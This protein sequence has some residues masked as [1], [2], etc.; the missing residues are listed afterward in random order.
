MRHA[1]RIGAAVVAPLVFGFPGA[2][3]RAAAE[4]SPLTEVIVTAQ[5]QEQKL[6]E[7]P[8]A[9]TAIS[10]ELLDARGQTRIADVTAQAPNVL[11]QINPA[12]GGN[13]M[14]AYIRG[15]G[16]GDQSPSVDPG[17]G[18]YIDDVYFATLTSSA[19]E[20]VDL[21]RVEIL[22]GPQGTLAGM[23]SLGGSVK[24]F[25]RKPTGEGGYVEGLFGSLNR[26]EVRAS[27]DFALVSERLFARVSGLSRVRDGYVTRLDYACVHPNDPYVISGAIAR[28]N[29]G[30]D[31]RIGTLGAVSVTAVRGALRWVASDRIE[32]NLVADAASD[33]SETQASVLRNAGEIIPGLALSY[34]GVPYDNRFT[35]Y[36]PNRGDTLIN[37]PYVSYANFI[38]PGVT[39]TPIDV[40]GNPGTNNGT[41]YAKPANE[42]DSWG[43]SASL[44][45]RFSDRLALK[46][47]SGYRR[48][49]TLSGQDNDGSPVAILQSLSEFRHHQVSQE[50]RLSGQAFGELLDYTLGGI[51]FKHETV[52][53]TRESD[54]FIP[55]GTDP[56]NRPIFDFIQDDTTDN[57]FKGIFLHTNWHPIRRLGV[58]AGVRY[59]KQNKDYTFYRYNI[60]GVSPFQPLS[61]P[62]NPL[63]GRVGNFNGSHTDYRLSL[64]YR[65][66]AEVMTYA[67]YATGFKGG[68]ISPRPYFPEQILGFGPEEIDAYEVGLKS[69]WFNQ[70]LQANVAL[71]YND[72]QGYQATPNQCVDASGSIL[73][74]PFGLPGLCGQYLNVADATVKGAEL[75][76]EISPIE[77]LSIDAAYSYLDFEFG[78]PYIQTSAVIAGRSAPGLGKNKWSAGAQYE[79]GFRTAGTLTP[80]VDVYYTPGY[81]G[82]LTCTPISRNEAYTLV[83]ARLVYRTAD[84]SWS[85]ALEGSNLT[86]KLYDLNKFNT[87]YASSQPGLP[88]Q[89]ALSVKRRF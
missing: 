68:G 57:E 31:C 39:Y 8:L 14:R 50:I 79:F 9:I 53:E 22:R 69:R 44:D 15:V 42:S 58:S 36:G 34:Q 45:W 12:G 18:L 23:N 48:Y 67:Q 7:T 43:V 76:L 5:F 80:R 77:H 4:E 26:R 24:L 38:N 6:Q 13:S 47:I 73:P 86:D 19:F 28:S 89:W 87:S 54:P 21:E 46:S 74:P 72:Y 75:E 17:V 61:N 51:Y 49:D 71:F 84:D 63:N 1:H 81:C 59:T 40:A 11:L 32:V 3:A 70:R 29:A 66:T 37:D 20:L 65:W 30:P 88:R 82:N 41:F 35:P 60:D 27:A 56:F 16:Q 83:N 52:Y 2:A 85:I 25:S 62:A 10:G 64:D 78:T 33:R 55:F